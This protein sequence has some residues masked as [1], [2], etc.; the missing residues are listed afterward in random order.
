MSYLEEK[1][2]LL[3]EKNKAEQITEQRETLEQ[4]ATE[5]C[6]PYAKHLA[7][8]LGLAEPRKGM[9]IVGV[10]K[11]VVSTTEGENW[12]NAIHFAKRKRNKKNFRKLYS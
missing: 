5:D 6:V 2:K 8:N 12:L 4:K 10:K 9:I 1:H 7:V 3:N 11:G